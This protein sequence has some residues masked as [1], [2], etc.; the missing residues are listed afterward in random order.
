[1]LNVIYV[2]DQRR[3]ER[4]LEYKD[5]IR[6]SEYVNVITYCADVSTECIS[7]LNADGVICHSGMV[8][9][10]VVIHFAKK[11]NWPL[12][13]YSGSVDST[14]YLRENKFSKNQYS[15]DSEYF[16]EVLPEFIARCQS[17]KEAG[18]YDV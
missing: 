11:N 4:N 13:S 8:G 5:F 18:S 2:E 17:I 1:M 14:P 6:S 15:V 16:K 10:E 7:K 12:L 9:Y 3:P